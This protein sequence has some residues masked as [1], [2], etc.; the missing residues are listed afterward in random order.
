MFL[1]KSEGQTFQHEATQARSSATAAGVV[2]TESLQT[3]DQLWLVGGWATPLKNINQWE[4]LSHILWKIKNVP[5]H[6]PGEYY[7]SLEQW[8]RPKI[9]PSN[10]CSCR[11]A[12][13]SCLTQGQQSPCQWCNVLEQD[14]CSDGLTAWTGTFHVQSSSYL[15][16]EGTNL[17][18]KR[19]PM[20]TSPRAKLFA[21][22]SFPEINC[23]GWKSWR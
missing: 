2:H 22:S 8:K 15:R 9:C 10:L 1:G 7:K 4:G 5:N 18:E 21:A 11:P 23:S 6:Q 3:L 19:I 14:Y 13:E 20:W 16:P 17:A 12:F